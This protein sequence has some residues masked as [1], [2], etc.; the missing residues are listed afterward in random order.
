MHEIVYLTGSDGVQRDK[1]EQ[2]TC[3]GYD[4][5]I[6]QGWFWERGSR[7]QECVRAGRNGGLRIG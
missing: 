1:T 4:W 5:W 3:I 2:I 7:M 6:A